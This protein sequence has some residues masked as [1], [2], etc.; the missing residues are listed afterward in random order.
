MT[1]L[2]RHFRP[3]LERLESRDT[4]S[5]FTV[6]FSVLTHTLTIVGDS[7]NNSLT[8]QGDAGDLTRFHLSSP[9][10]TFN[11]NPGTFDSPSGVKNIT[12]R[13]LGGDDSVTFGNSVLIDLKGNLSINGG[14][15]SNS[16]T[17]T[18]LKPEKNLSIL[19][20]TKPA[21]AHSR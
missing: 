9:S 10:D 11:G 8:V 3:R 2:R 4:P 13:M 16:V 6:S 14:D 21:G 5:N 19:N 18:K 1:P 7:A 15:G 20:C 17:A 12:I